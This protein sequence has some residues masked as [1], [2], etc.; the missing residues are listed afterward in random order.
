MKS[1]PWCGERHASDRLC[2]R[3]LTRRSFCFLFGAGIAA[4]ALP[5]RAGPVALPFD[6]STE[7]ID[8]LFAPTVA[9]FRTQD[10]LRVGQE[11][12]IAFSDGRQL[13]GGTIDQISNYDGEQRVHAIDLEEF[14]RRQRDADRRAIIWK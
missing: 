3:G 13:F 1:C 14:A 8:R 2:Q 4:A 11:I 6:G 9:N 5:G 10:Y 12:T 7:I